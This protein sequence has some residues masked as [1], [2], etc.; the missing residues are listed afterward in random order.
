[1][2]TDYLKHATTNDTPEQISLYSVNLQRI[3]GSRESMSKYQAKWV[4]VVNVASKCGFTP[5]YEG[6]EKLY[7]EYQFRDFTILGF[8]CNQFMRQEPASDSEV[9]QFCSTR[10]QVTFPMFAKTDVNGPNTHPLYIFLKARARSWLGIQ[11]IGWNF[12]KFL[13][14][15]D[16]SEV[17]RFGPTTTPKAI[18]QRLK[19]LIRG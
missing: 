15:P 9:L 4:L 6:L 13:I 8:P 3:D 10:Y 2:T 5:Q 16:G 11:R 18:G 19:Q 1:M 12:T 17:E 7:Q 14:N